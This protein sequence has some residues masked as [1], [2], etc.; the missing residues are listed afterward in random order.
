MAATS[1]GHGY[2]FV[3]S[4]GGVFA[5]GDAGFLGSAGGTAIGRPGRRDGRRPGHRGYWLVGT[6]GGVFAYGE[7]FFGSMG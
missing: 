5:Y 1:D 3:A 6:D 4:D 7:P 2:W